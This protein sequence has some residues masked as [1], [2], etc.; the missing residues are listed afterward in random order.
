MTDAE[1]ELLTRKLALRIARIIDE[2]TSDPLTV[3]TS[4]C[5]VLSTYA[6]V[7]QTPTDELFENFRA[8]RKWVESQPEIAAWM[9]SRNQTTEEKQ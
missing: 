1:R 5:S 3:M 9:E 6:A 4:L 2:T 7:F 8:C